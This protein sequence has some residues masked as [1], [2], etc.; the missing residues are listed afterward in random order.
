MAPMENA[1]SIDIVARCTPR[2]GPMHEKVYGTYLVDQLSETRI[3]VPNYSVFL[4]VRHV[5]ARAGCR[6]ASTLACS[7]YSDWFRATVSDPVQSCRYIHTYVRL[8]PV[9]FST[10]IFH[11]KLSS[12]HRPWFGSKNTPSRCLYR[13]CFPPTFVSLFPLPIILSLN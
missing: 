10:L 2:A 4:G 11:A 5:P 13:M 7:C 3:A 9:F 6:A 1:C 12:Q 8:E